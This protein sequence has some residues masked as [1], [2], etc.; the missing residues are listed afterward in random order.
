M[1]PASHEGVRCIGGTEPRDGLKRDISRYLEKSGFIDRV[2]MDILET[3][4]KTIKV[5]LWAGFCLLNLLLL[6]VLGTNPSVLAEILHEDLGQ[7]FFLV[8][9]ISLLGGMIGLVM[10]SDI[11]WLKEYMPKKENPDRL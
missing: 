10:V 4:G 9:G 1:N 6:L 8:L 2:M 3:P 5:L 7:F 11:S